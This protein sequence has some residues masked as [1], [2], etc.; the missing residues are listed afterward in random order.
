[1]KM[2][3]LLQTTLQMIW[4]KMTGRM[5]VE[6]TGYSLKPFYIRQREYAKSLSYLSV[7]REGS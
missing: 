2:G 6:P 1:M 3:K 7:T 4:G 5:N